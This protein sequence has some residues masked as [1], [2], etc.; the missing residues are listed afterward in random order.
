M[1]TTVEAIYENG[2]LVLQ[3]PLPLPDKSPVQVTIESLPA[4][5]I[6]SNEEKAV[7]LLNNAASKRDYE[8][9][10][11][12]VCEMGFDPDTIEHEPWK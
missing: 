9:A 4:A 1:T 7:F 10:R 2:K 6:Y 5:R 8:N 12:K 11:Q 3:K